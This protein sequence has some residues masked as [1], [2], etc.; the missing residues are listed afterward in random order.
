MN[1]F[2]TGAAGFIGGSIATGPDPRRSGSPVWCAAP[3]KRMN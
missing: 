1:V 3:N 2:V